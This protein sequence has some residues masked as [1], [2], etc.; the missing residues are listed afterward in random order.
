MPAVVFMLKSGA[1][2]HRIIEKDLFYIMD[3]TNY[4]KEDFFNGGTGGDQKCGEA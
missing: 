3:T 2:L 4:I 1:F